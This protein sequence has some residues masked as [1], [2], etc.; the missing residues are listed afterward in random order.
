MVNTNRPLLQEIEELS[1]IVDAQ[2]ARIIEL[3]G[4]VVDEL[5]RAETARDELQRVMVWLIRIGEEVQDRVFGIL[6]DATMLIDEVMD[7]V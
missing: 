4:T 7:V 5:V 3:E 6:A 1:A 2:G